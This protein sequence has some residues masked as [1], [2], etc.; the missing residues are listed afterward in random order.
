VTPGPLKQDAANRIRA[1]IEHEL[2]V[3]A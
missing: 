1:H 3:S 2:G